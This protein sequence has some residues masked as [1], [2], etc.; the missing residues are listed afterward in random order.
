MM[1]ISNDLVAQAVQLLESVPT[2][3]KKADLMSL[4]S[5]QSE[6]L[7]QK[8]WNALLDRD[9]VE[10][11]GNGRGVVLQYKTVIPRDISVSAVITHAWEDE[12]DAPDVKTYPRVRARI[13]QSLQG[14]VLLS[15]QALKGRCEQR[16]PFDKILEALI[17]EEKVIMITRNGKTLYGAG[18]NYSSN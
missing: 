1:I 16:V 9:G 3:I 7:Q 11:T 6:H 14:S 15:Y 13:L 17:A 10:R 2:G 12:V 5:I 4:L 8:L 18:P